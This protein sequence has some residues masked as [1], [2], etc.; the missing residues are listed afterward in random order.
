MWHNV[1][2]CVFDLILKIDAQYHDPDPCHGVDCTTTQIFGDGPRTAN[3][4]PM[5]GFAQDSKRHVGE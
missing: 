3:P 1:I 5:N 2:Q 4:P